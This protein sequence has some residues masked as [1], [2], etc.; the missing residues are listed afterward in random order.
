MLIL[1]PLLGR[2]SRLSDSLF[3][4]WFGPLG[5]A[6]IFYA[7]LALRHTGQDEPWIVGSL[8]VCA[9]I[10]IHGLSATPLA[11]AYA[12]VSDRHGAVVSPHA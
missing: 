10:L 2:L 12:R 1:R 8:V 9:S 3:I 4:G 5:A 11:K 7:M 6:A